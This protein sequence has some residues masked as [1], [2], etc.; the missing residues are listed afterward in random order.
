MSKVKHYQKEIL[1]MLE[2]LRIGKRHKA[3]AKKF[4]YLPYMIVRYEEMLGDPLPL[5]KAFEKEPNDAIRCNFLKTS[6]YD[7][8]KRLEE[9]GFVL[10]QVPWSPH[11]F[12]VLKQPFSISSTPEHLDGWFFIQDKASTL[13]PLVLDPKPF[14]RVADLASAPGG[15][16]TY[17]AH[18]MG[19]SGELYLF[20]R[21]KDRA[22][23]LMSNLERMEVLNA[24]PL[25]E[26]AYNAPKYGPFDKA[27]LDAP[28]TGEGV[29][30]RD[31]SRKT[32]R[33]PKDLA[34]MHKV[35]VVLLNRALDSLKSGGELVYSTCS[36]AP[37]ENEM[38]I[39]TVL[40]S[41]EDVEVM[42]SGEAGSPGITKYFGFEFPFAIK[43]R[44]LWPHVHGSEGFFVC[45]LKKF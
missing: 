7:L 9:R 27:L 18:L 33:K 2:N 15:K 11:A 16:A 10:E 17:L 34:L 40:K 37:E 21:R 4:G 12:E 35:Q 32:S 5:L 25:I 14:Q 38:V 41:R 36:I 30:A 1:R 23:A 44:R 28:C 6:C 19:N 26:D 45:K 42:D 39:D 22:K 24:I 20:E 43:C 8:K 31:P 29:I 3:L 13:P